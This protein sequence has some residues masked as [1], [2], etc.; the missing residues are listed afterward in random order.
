MAKWYINKER[1]AIRY[2]SFIKGSLSRV[3]KRKLNNRLSLGSV[4]LQGQIIYKK[5][6]MHIQ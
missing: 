6:L 5:K 2:I 1:S 4:L 3:L